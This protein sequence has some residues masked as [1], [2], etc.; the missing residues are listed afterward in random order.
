MKN[1]DF[2][3][4]GFKSSRLPFGLRCSP[5]ILMLS[6]YY[7]LIVN[8]CEADSAKLVNLKRSIYDLVYMDNGAITAETTEDILWAFNHIRDIFQIQYSAN[9]IER[10]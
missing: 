3:V 4:V 1:Y 8:T 7:I 10:L 9:C 5:S 2:T 6:L